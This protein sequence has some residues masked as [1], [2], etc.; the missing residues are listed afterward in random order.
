[1][2]YYLMIK[3]GELLI[4]CNKMDEPRK[5]AR[6]KPMTKDVFYDFIC[7]QCPEWADLESRKNMSGY[8]GSGGLGK[9]EG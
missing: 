8:L 1:M 9:T 3:G 4:T 5:H 7:M 2:E 6:K